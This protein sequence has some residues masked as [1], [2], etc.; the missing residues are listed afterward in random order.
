MKELLHILDQVPEFQQLLD[1]LD[2]GRS[3]AAVSGLSP[4][5]RAHF[6]AGIRQETGRPV[7]VV[8]ADE[9]EARRLAGDLAGLAGEEPALLAARLKLADTVRSVLANGLGLLGVSAP[10]KM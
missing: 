2:A 5:H 10:E 1:A 3:P 9:L 8:C 6:A 4:V 7:V